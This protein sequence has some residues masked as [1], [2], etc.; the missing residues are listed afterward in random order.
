MEKTP[1]MG[2]PVRELFFISENDFFTVRNI[3]QKNQQ[4]NLQLISFP[5]PHNKLEI[6]ANRTAI[7]VVRPPRL[8]CPLSALN[9]V[10]RIALNALYRLQ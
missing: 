7:N 6:T 2:K 5:M 1:T 8:L 3:Q 4:A 10:V 9:A